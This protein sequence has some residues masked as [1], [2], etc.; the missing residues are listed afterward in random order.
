MYINFVELIIML[1]CNLNFRNR[2]GGGAKMKAF[3]TKERRNSVEHILN[4]KHAH[5]HYFE[6]PNIDKM[7][8]KLIKTHLLYILKEYT[9]VLTFLLWQFCHVLSH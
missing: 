1:S 6:I 3:I 4:T 9:V 8:L 7:Y 5:V 2:G